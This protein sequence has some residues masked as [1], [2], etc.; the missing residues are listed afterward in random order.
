MK[1]GKI[2]LITAVI[3]C[4]LSLTGCGSNKKKSSDN[5]IKIYYL[6]KSETKLVT[7]NYNMTKST[8]EDQIKE[9]LKTINKVSSKLNCIK[10]LPDDVKVND[11]N[12]S[13]HDLTVNFSLEYRNMNRI[14]ELLCRSA[15]VLT[16]SQ[17]KGVDYV[18]FMVQNEPLMNNENE[19]VGMMKESDFVDCSGSAINNYQNIQVKLYF[20]N[21][22]G[23]KLV[24]DTYN[25]VYSK[26]ISLERYVVE[27]L[28]KGPTD[29]KMT[30]T[31]P[32]DTKIISV[33]TK[34]GIC[35]VNLD[36][37]FLTETV[38]VT[39]DVEIYSIV[40]SLCELSTVN[41]VQFSIN[42]EM[43][44]KL[45]NS[46]ELSGLFSRDLDIIKNAKK[47]K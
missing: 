42:G 41:K 13:E 46:F 14:R 45:H 38:N 11:W 16:L 9:V 10:A 25:G 20:G 18:T 37:K 19:P 7:E 23:D 33:T 21:G 44:K 29:D 39:D 27:K 5:T 26:N 40:N 17:I 47:K 24:E 1:Y 32:A 34:D 12:I 43:D 22:Q 3:L 35:Y 6:N 4:I 30:R 31:I 8:Q 2:L 36:E 28:I 15:V